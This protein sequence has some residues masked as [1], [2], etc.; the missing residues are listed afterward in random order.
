[1]KFLG[2]FYW[3]SEDRTIAEECGA[4]GEAM[5]LCSWAP[6]KIFKKELFRD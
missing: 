4:T 6:Q 1:M 5:E 3:V 2:K